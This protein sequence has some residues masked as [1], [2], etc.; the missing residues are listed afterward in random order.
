M[1]AP[2]SRF[3]ASVGKVVAIRVEVPAISRGVMVS[4][5][6]AL[7]CTGMRFLSRPVRI[8]GPCKSPRIQIGF[9]SS[10]DTLRTISMSFSFSAWVPWEKLSRATS[11]P[12]RTSSRKTVSVL[13]EGPRV[14]TILA[15]R[16]GSA[17]EV[18]LAAIR[19]KLIRPSH[20]LAGGGDGFQ[21]LQFYAYS[22]T[23]DSPA[24][25]MFCWG[26]L[27]PNRHHLFLFCRDHLG[28]RP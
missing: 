6:P 3:S 8:F 28:Q 12:A 15:R 21:Q 13:Q 2:G 17:P 24:H 25:L 10:L 18:S 26:T 22:G 14:A 9:P 5:W 1:R 16:R 27:S 4:R 7:S 23:N 20:W 11:S 19:L